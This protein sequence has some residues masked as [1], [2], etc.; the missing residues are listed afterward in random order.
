MAD[1]FGEG[2]CEESGFGG[3]GDG[4]SCG[5]EVSGEVG[6]GCGV[7]LV[8]GLE[9]GGGGGW[10]CG[11]A[12]DGSGRGEGD[13]ADEEC[14][15]DEDGCAEDLS[16][17]EAGFGGCG[18][19]GG[20]DG[21]GGGGDVED[22]GVARGGGDADGEGLAEGDEEALS[23]DGEAVHGGLAELAGG[24]DADGSGGVVGDDEVGLA[25]PSERQDE[26]GVRE[27][28]DADDGGVQE[29][30]LGCEGETDG[31]AEA[32]HGGEQLIVNS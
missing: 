15:A 25:D 26:D 8:S 12:G 32:G 18:G 17:G 29:E 9:L 14:D 6:G 24:F 28:S 2:V 16:E 3:V 5:G 23:R 11:G 10:E 30:V 22:E 19:D 13:V 20:D 1:G 31:D 4:E 7:E 27:L 21:C